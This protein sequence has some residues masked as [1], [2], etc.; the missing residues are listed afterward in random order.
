MKSLKIASAIA[1]V[2]A[3][4]LLTMNYANA[5]VLAQLP[6]DTSIPV[7][8]T[9]FPDA[10]FRE[11]VAGI[12]GDDGMLDPS[13]RDAVIRISL[14]GKEIGSLKGIG[15]FENLKRLECGNNLLTD[16]DLSQNT[17]LTE[18]FCSKNS[19]KRLN[20][21]K[22]VALEMLDCSSNKLTALDVSKNTA[23][24]YLKCSGN[25][26]ET[27]DLSNLSKMDTLLCDQRPFGKDCKKINTLNLSGANAI[28]VIEFDSNAISVMELSG[29]SKL[30][31]VTCSDN[32]IQKLDLSSAASLETLS[33][34]GNQLTSLDLSA[35]V[36]LHSVDCSNNALTTLKLPA[37]TAATS[38]YVG[39]NQLKELDA[40]KMPNLNYF[41][42]DSN[43]I[44]KLT[45]NASGTLKSLSCTGNKITKLDLSG[46]TKLETLNCENNQLT[47]LLLTGDTS[48][49]QIWCYE[50]QLT[51][52]DVSGNAS[53][54][55]LFCEA[56]NL[57]TL[58]LSGATALEKLE[59]ELNALTSLNLST[60]V[61]LRTL[62]CYSNSIKTIN[63]DTCPNLKKAAEGDFT[64]SNAYY[65]S[66]YFTV[67]SF[68]RF[69]AASLGSWILC[70][71][72]TA[73]VASGLTPTPTPLAK[74]SNLKAKEVSDFDLVAVTVYWNAVPGATG[75]KISRTDPL[76]GQWCGA[77]SVSNGSTS[78]TFYYIFPDTTYSFKVCADTDDNRFPNPES[79][80]TFTTKADTVQPLTDITVKL[81][82]TYRYEVHNILSG[83]LTFKTG[84]TS[85]ATV[86][87]RGNIT[88]KS[89]GNTYLYVG[90]PNGKTIKCL[91]RVTYPD[92]K[93]CYTEKTLYPCQTFAF[94]VT[95]AT[96][97]KITWSVGNTAVATIDASGKVTAKRIANTY[98]YAK[99]ADGRSA[100]C[101]L[102]VVD[103]GELG[104]NY[105]EKTIF[106]GQSFTFTAK[107]ARVFTP[108]WSVGNTA[109][110][111][112][113]A[114]TG[115]VTS[116][117]V[118]NTYLYV[119]TADGR[120]ARCLIKV[121]DPGPLNIRYSEKTIKVGA[122]FKFTCS[123]PAGQT[124]TW[125]VGNTAVAT[126]DANGNV[127]GKKAANTWLYA[128]TPDG[129][130]TKCLLKI[131][132]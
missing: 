37:S 105:T 96:G 52:L 5:K 24:W 114:T 95:G 72:T 30:Y 47:S 84:N 49:K 29:K 119:K 59:C 102:K 7:N 61:S 111:K 94:T 9:N 31:S 129:R 75:Y 50:N 131:V 64:V 15:Y 89:L 110:A 20:V 38:V 122:T 35:C 65:N 78:Y 6:S 87:D 67:H 42:C 36:K 51:S 60:N 14:I 56:N 101:L 127:T 80:I 92:L 53:L 113:N 107:N 108:T 48:L 126:V 1:A 103:P 79:V 45:L 43:Q 71:V 115:K 132:A 32:K 99:S 19:L 2:A 66:A 117:S 54:T 81:G 44:T 90:L 25:Q 22:C 12:A 123:N 106:L 57:K 27:L 104:I 46:Y 62:V 70:D 8:A 97:Q 116:V 86:D 88:A 16:L 121:V 124:V 40:S 39:N 68:P 18:V 74:P 63:V 11:Y 98:L 76:S 128:S 28:R 26:F 3:S 77:D 100:K 55:E 4:V 33:C 130:E 17:Q 10:T 41:D 125:R 120:S 85:V 109:V 93:I 23:L 83:Y 91:V 82:D 58:K 21:S 118:G 69:N 73:I 34:R 13:E 112:V